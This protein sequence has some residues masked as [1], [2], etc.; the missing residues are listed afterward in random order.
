[1][2]SSVSTKSQVS[3]YVNPAERDRSRPSVARS[4]PE[5]PPGP[6]SRL[7]RTL[8]VAAKQVDRGSAAASATHSLAWGMFRLPP[9]YRRV[10]RSARATPLAGRAS[11]P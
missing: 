5:R 10:G 4:W 8:G 3:W 1:V 7:R 6:G 9:P 11:L 2:L